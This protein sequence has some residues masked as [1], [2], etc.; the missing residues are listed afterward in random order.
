MLNR[1]LV[2]AGSPHVGEEA[3]VVWTWLLIARSVGGLDRRIDL[4][5]S[6]IHTASIHGTHEVVPLQLGL[7]RTE[8]DRVR[9]IRFDGSLT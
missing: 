9:G 6:K 4:R 1:S 5:R 2:V 3:V 7:A 8:V